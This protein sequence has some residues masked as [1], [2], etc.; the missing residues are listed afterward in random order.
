MEDEE[1]STSWREGAEARCTSNCLAQ[2]VSPG[3]K[4][5]T[6]GWQI[7][8]T[9]WFCLACSTSFSSERLAQRHSNRELHYSNIRNAE[10]QPMS[11]HSPGNL[12]QPIQH[13][14]GRVG[15]LRDFLSDI[16]MNNLGLPQTQPPTSRG[17]PMPSY[18]QVQANSSSAHFI[19]HLM[20]LFDFT[21]EDQDV[22]CHLEQLLMVCKH[23]FVV[24][25]AA[26]NAQTL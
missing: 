21:E 4:M 7:T 24:L 18:P 15:H 12:P 19:T 6:A 26:I 1:S 10:V 2:A 20:Q 14:E 5:P 13:D 3:L 9:S 25:T 8:P 11:V 16:H 17:S 22:R 23:V